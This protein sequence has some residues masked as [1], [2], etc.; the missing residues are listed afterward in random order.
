MGEAAISLTRGGTDGRL[1]GMKRIIYPGTFD[2]PTNGHL[3]IVQRASG[4]FEH[5]DVVISVNPRKQ[6]LFDDAERLQMMQAMVVGLPNVQV[7]VWAGLIV[8][9]AERLGARIILRGVRAL[10]DFEY[11]FELALMQKHLNRDIETIFLPT[12]QEHF[13]LRSSTI[14]EIA[15]FGGDVTDM[16]P[17]VV[18]QA[19]RRK[20]PDPYSPH[21]PVS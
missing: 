15:Q 4:M 19:L 12:A 21:S 2:P 7:H 13:L 17:P 18:E 11:E 9:L 10:S 1:Q 3:N 16:V 8:E 6:T 5:L 14:K 20:F